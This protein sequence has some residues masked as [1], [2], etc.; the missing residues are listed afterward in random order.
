MMEIITALILQDLV[1]IKL[2]DVCKT[3]NTESDTQHCP[4]CFKSVVP[5]WA[6]I[7]LCHPL[8]D[9]WQY[10]ET[11]FVATTWGGTLLARA[12]Y[13]PRMPLNSLQRTGQPLTERILQP[14][15]STASRLRNPALP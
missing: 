13:N 4:L 15:T 10:L 11:S 7:G 9:I 2:D 12:E 6:A 8:G 5:Y 14:K 1:K 3:I